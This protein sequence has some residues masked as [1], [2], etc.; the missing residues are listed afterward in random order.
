MF[1]GFSL[2]GKPEKLSSIYILKEYQ[3][4]GIKKLLV[5]LVIRKL[6]AMGINTMLVFVLEDNQ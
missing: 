6:E 4:Q 5:E 3:G 2:Q 1:F